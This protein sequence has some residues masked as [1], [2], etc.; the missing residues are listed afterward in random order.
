MNPSINKMKPFRV[1]TMRDEQQ[2]AI[3]SLDKIGGVVYSSE[4]NGKFYARGYLRNGRNPKFNYMFSTEA[5]RTEYVT[6]WANDLAEREASK[7]A[8]RAKKKAARHTLVVGDVLSA[9]WGYG[10]SNVNY[11]QV[12]ELKAK[13]MVK[14]RE[15]ASIQVDDSHV[16]PA[17]DSFINYKIYSKRVHPEYNSVNIS[18]CQHASPVSKDENGNYTSSY[19]TPFG[20]GH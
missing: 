20:M 15:I 13:T 8:A 12:I 17:V 7:V 1:N 4:L 9:L 5:R 11:Y 2:V 18:S 16:K 14:L 19:K 10:Q 3:K 6:N